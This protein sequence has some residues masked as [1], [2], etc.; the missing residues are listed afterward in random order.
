AYQQCATEYPQ[1]YSQFEL[2][3]VLD[4]LQSTNSGASIRELRFRTV[5]EVVDEQQSSS[6]NSHIVN[7]ITRHCAGYFDAGQAA[8]HNPWQGAGL[9]QAWRE[10]MRYSHRMD[11][12]GLH[13]F[14]EFVEQLPADPRKAVQELLLTLDV[15]ATHFRPVLLCTAFSVS[16][17]ASFIRYQVRKAEAQGQVNDDLIGLV[18]MRLAYDVALSRQPEVSR[19][20]ALWPAD[21]ASAGDVAVPPA[22]TADVLARYVLQVAVERTYRTD[23]LQK[24][25]TVKPGSRPVSRKLL[26][27]VFCIDV[28]SEVFRRN[29]ES[30][31]A[32][33]ETFGFAGFF[34]MPI[35]YAP[36]GFENGSAQC[37]VLLQPSFRVPETLHGLEAHDQEQAVQQRGTV[38]LG[39]KLWK[40]F[41]TSATACFTYVES[42]GWT[43]L[44]KLL[45]DS[46]SWSRPVASAEHD[47]VPTGFCE[48]LGPD[49]QAAEAHGLPAAR[50]VDVAENML[51]NLG[52]VND[53]ARLVT[54]CG[55]ASQ[56]TNNP[57]RAALDCGACGGHSGEP[58]ARFAA[59]LLND[60]EV[61]LGL[62]AR[63]IVIPHT[64]W[65]LA[66]VHETTTDNIKICDRHLVPTSHAIDLAEV[67]RWFIEAGR[68]TRAERS[69]RLGA[70]DASQVLA[71]SVDW[72]EI[73][74]E[75]GLAGNAAFIVAPRSRTAGLNLGG[76]TFLH[77]YDQQLDP[78][79]KVLEL[80]LT[81][82]MVV[83]N[84]INFQYYASTVDPVA[85]GSGNKLIHNVVGQFGVLQGNGGDLMGGLPWQ[86]IHDGE[87]LQHEPLRLLVVVEANRSTLQKIIETHAIVRQLISH[88]W[89]T[90][91]A[92]EGNQFYRWTAQGNW[93]NAAN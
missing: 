57:Y 76:R 45:T 34:G 21:T 1:W 36:L 67:E 22:P 88:G 12:L 83:A 62:A 46:F 10:A 75:W 30:V 70:T 72:A 47:G 69:P 64:T 19:P 68:L 93:D 32:G 7:D 13:G 11:M 78:Q 81:A 86:S 77:S 84:W 14:R 85:F 41:Q 79:A 92:W 16:G 38:R 33:V 15:P 48:H 28:R 50:R 54:L 23:L 31:D 37:P 60:G 40:S 4:W 2:S 51:R 35:E 66:A 44:G 42:L 74:P 80:I 6:W 27:M 87:Q 90:L 56:V 52:L 82:P 65:F 24:L 29:L 73:R 89:V 17:W 61:R 55:H 58:N 25:A 53:F 59:A 49:L 5:A 20:L 8:W 43:F 63:G 18:A 91:V 39:R 26:Q 9:Y 71:K 3:E